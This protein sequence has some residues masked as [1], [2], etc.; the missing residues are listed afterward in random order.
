MKL[1]Q[2]LEGFMKN[3][4]NKTARETVAASLALMPTNSWHPFTYS[5]FGKY[6]CHQ[7]SEWNRQSRAINNSWCH[8]GIPI[9]ARAL[10]ASHNYKWFRFNFTC[11]LYEINKYCRGDCR[12]KKCVVLAYFR[13]S[14]WNKSVL[15][16]LGIILKSFQDRFSDNYTRVPWGECIFV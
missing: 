14:I 6:L 4:G 1:A 7:G 9:Y 8:Q 2:G 12:A 15:D 5:P 11:T 16:K 10:K 3:R 13:D